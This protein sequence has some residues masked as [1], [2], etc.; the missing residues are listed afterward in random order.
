VLDRARIEPSDTV[1]AVGAGN[2]LL[3]FG[4][5]DR[6]DGGWT[7]AVDPSADCLEELLRLAHESGRSGIMYLIGGAEALPLPDCFADAVVTQSALMDVDD[8]AAAARELY[9]VLRPGGRVSLFEPVNRKG[10]SIS[11]AVDWSPLGAGLAGRVADES[12]RYAASSRLHRLDD[13]RL[14]AELEAAGFASVESVLED[15]GEEWEV[16]EAS[17]DSRLDAVDAPGEPSLRARWAESFAAAELEALVAHLKSLEGETL[18]FRRPAV[19]VAAR[20]P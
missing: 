17:V 6:L 18:E 16:T 15:P 19:F 7:V 20:K 5:A 13:E 12:R 3:S 8:S 4:A 9:R 1:V 11:T 2:G 14:A 10:T